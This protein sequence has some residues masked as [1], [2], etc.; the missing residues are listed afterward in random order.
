VAVSGLGFNVIGGSTALPGAIGT[1]L[2]LEG[3]HLPAGRAD[4]ADCS[5]VIVFAA[6]WGV[7]DVPAA[8][9]EEAAAVRA[10]AYQPP[11]HRTTRV[12]SN[13]DMRRVPIR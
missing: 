3:R 9:V 1:A 7:V 6:G 2:C 11:T 13:S 5:L 4:D 8:V 10:A 12:A